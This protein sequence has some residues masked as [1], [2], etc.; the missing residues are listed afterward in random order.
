MKS[1]VQTSSNWLK[2]TPPTD[3][4]RPGL[5]PHAPYST[6]VGLFRHAVAAGVPVAF[7]LAESAAEV[8][9]LE[10]RTG[11]FV[12]FL[13]SL[14]VWQPDAL[15]T[16]VNEYPVLAGAIRSRNRPPLM[17]VHGNHLNQDMTLPDP[18]TSV[19]YCPRTHAAFGHPP[20]PFRAFLANGNRVC[21]GTDGLTSNPDL[22]ILAEA[23]FL[24]RHHPDLPGET[25]L[26]MVTLSG[27]E[28]LGWADETGSLTPGKSADAV[29]VPL[30]DRDDSADPHDNLFAP[31]LSGF[32][33][34]TLFR[35][36]WR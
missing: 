23:R 18:A 11:P 3:T 13:Q 29:A 21:L 5:S 34:R 28:A 15:G 31:D 8:E 17:F 2:S 22:D 1:S 27:A 14:G 6:S 33:R 4:C 7:H 24:R 32:P 25:L 19:V 16:S 10:H 26:R 20:H 30:A 9:L 35:G 12:P 36:E